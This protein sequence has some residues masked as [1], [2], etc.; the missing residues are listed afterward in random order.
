MKKIV[1]VSCLL[2]AIGSNVNAQI[3]L[4]PTSSHRLNVKAVGL[5]DLWGVFGTTSTANTNMVFRRGISN[6]NNWQSTGTIAGT[7]G[8]SGTENMGLKLASYDKD[9]GL[10]GIEKLKLGT[11]GDF[12]R[13]VILENGNVGINYSTPNSKLDIY[14]NGPTLSGSVF[15]FGNSVWRVNSQ[16][17]GNDFTSLT[18]GA[19]SIGLL[20]S[21]GNTAGSG[22][23]ANVGLVG[24][25]NNNA[26][27]NIGVLGVQNANTSGLFLNIVGVKGQVT[28]TELNV[29]MGVYGKVSGNSASGGV[30]Y[31]VYG[32]A[33]GTGGTIYAGYFSGN[34]ATTGFTQ[35]GSDAPKIKVKKITGFTQTTQDAYRA[36]PHGLALDKILSVEV[37][38]SVSSTVKHFKKWTSYINHEFDYYVDATNVQIFNIPGNSGSILNK[39]LT[40]YITYEE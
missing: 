28:R 18:G 16:A 32:E 24:T 14:G 9:L 5:G 10:Y 36:I 4:N 11:N 15:G 34:V 19:V 22:A 25:T 29:A 21:A 26:I 38:V 33:S 7:L 23:I 40:I 1:L 6:T 27:E 12:N 13:M 37:V 3:E 39:P 35:L 17:N 8:Y 2:V 31:G 20:G 30:G